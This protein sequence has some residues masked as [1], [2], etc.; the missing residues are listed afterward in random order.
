MRRGSVNVEFRVFDDH[1]DDPRTVPNAAVTI[2]DIGTQRTSNGRVTFTIPVNTAQEVSV[3]KDGY[4]TAERTLSVGESN[5]EVS[6]TIQRTPELNLTA[7]STRV[8]VG[9]RLRVSV[10]NAYG[11]PVNGADIS[12][13]SERLGQTGADGEFRLRVESSGNHTVQAQSGSLSSNTLT[14]RGF[15]PDAGTPTPTPT[16]TPVPTPTA[17]PTE[18]ETATPAVGLP[19]FTPAVA[20]LGLLLSALLLR[21]RD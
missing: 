2:E 13:D 15:D 18:T 14:V 9:N 11:E 6:A 17:T 4:Q 7:E 19:G 5:R 20:V 1:F 10:V 16:A 12:Y 3:T 8:L 21:R